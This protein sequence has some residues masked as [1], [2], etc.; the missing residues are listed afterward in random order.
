[1]GYAGV[2]LGILGCRAGEVG[3]R[4]LGLGMWTVRVRGY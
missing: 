2:G 3:Y 1:M 4:S